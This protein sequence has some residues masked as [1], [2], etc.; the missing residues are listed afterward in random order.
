MGSHTPTINQKSR[1]SIATN[2]RLNSSN[3]G[4]RIAPY[5]AHQRAQVGTL[6]AARGTRVA[7]RAGADHASATARFRADRAAVT[8]RSKANQLM[9]DLPL[10]GAGA[11]EDPGAQAVGA[12]DDR[13]GH[14]PSRRLAPSLA[15]GTAWIAPV[16][17]MM[18]N[19]KLRRGAFT[20]LRTTLSSK[21]KIRSPNLRSDDLGLWA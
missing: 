14:H 1:W 2:R 13:R 20:S 3:A 6:V 19:G 5:L 10:V 9:V 21:T 15:V 18:T 17:T 11:G 12:V 16:P 8:T 7:A 4:L